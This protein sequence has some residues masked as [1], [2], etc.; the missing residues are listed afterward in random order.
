M[1]D[2]AEVRLAAPIPCPPSVR[3]FLSFE[4]HLIEVE[5]LG[6]ITGRIVEG[7]AVVPLT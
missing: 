7:P 4:E 6:E 3:D 1:V 2:L 5:R